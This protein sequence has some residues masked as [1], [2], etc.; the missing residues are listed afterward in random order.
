VTMSE[1]PL[2]RILMVEDSENDAFLLLH[3]IQR[4]GYSVDCERVETAEAMKKA[5]EEESW[6]VIISD[7]NL[8]HFDA[9]QA[10]AVMK[11]QGY[12][13][14]FIIVSGTTSEENAVA[15]LKA[16]A[17][18]FVIKG[19][20]ARLVPAI[21]REIQDTITRREHRQ[22]SRELEAIASIS[23][24][25]R[26]AQTLDEMLSRLLN[27]TLELIKAEIGSIWLYDASTD[28]VNLVAQ[29]GW[30]AEDLITSFRRG[31]GIPGLVIKSGQ[32]F[33]S[34]EIF[35]D[36]RLTK[37]Y[38][39]NIPKGIGGA[40][41]PL[42]SDEN[43]VGV[44]FINV[45]LPREISDEEVRV[46]TALAEIGGNTVRRMLLLEQTLKQVQRLRSL[47]TIDVAI[48]SSLDLRISLKIV[49]EEA[50]T[51]LNIDAAS[52]LLINP[53]TKRLE[54]SEGL[55]FRTSNIK[56]TSLGRGEGFAGQVAL[57]KK[58]VYIKDLN[59]PD[60][61]F[62]RAE[63]L[64]NEEFITYFGTPLIS[65]GKVQGVLEIFNR[66]PLRPDIEW[67][68][69]FD[70][71]SWQTA[72]A[73]E[74]ALLFEDLQQSNFEIEAAYNATIEGWSRALDLRDKETE[75]HSMR[76]TEMTM[77]LAR[78]MG[79][80]EDLLIDVKRG[81]LLHD[82]G[83]MGVPDNILLKPGSLTKQEWHI[84]RQHPQYAYELLEPIAYL[85]QA[86]DIPYC[87]HEKWDGSGYPRGLKGEKI[88]LAA[89]IFAVVDVW[90]SLTNDRPYRQAWSH[91]K[92]LEYIRENSGSH[93]DPQ[94]VDAFLH[95]LPELLKK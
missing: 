11:E 42:H 77:K 57:E 82:I 48:S 12:D 92:T 64:K 58:I 80:N 33:I 62:E 91:T 50:I 30:D 3:E 34:P 51:Q 37:E 83:K 13:L 17:H 19:R 65:K 16:G 23:M 7:Y 44:I 49:L 66:A 93:F 32:T 38:Q 59:K 24:I 81:S 22:R 72:I 4:S 84:M 95:H 79:M 39:G 28:Q 86:L 43:I 52:I 90:D 78:L 35:T 88:P 15:A 26:K 36:P 56:L 68:N 27:Q 47:R 87:H 14:P 69:F 71:L 89:R 18:D 46:L 45:K 61:P 6:D 75:G 73:V 8:P 25:L 9:P 74:N 76:V 2:L 41:I 21:Q 94:V 1:I 40:C 10:L 55:G 70:A 5:L 29:R 60:Q 67:L 54:F 53:Q 20:L 31:Q 85:K 63:L